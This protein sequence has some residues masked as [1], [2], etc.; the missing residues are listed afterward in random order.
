[1]VLELLLLGRKGRDSDCPSKGTART[2][3]LAFEN[4]RLLHTSS[5]LSSSSPAFPLPLPGGYITPPAPA[6]EEQPDLGHG[7]A[8]SCGTSLRQLR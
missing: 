4:R 3:V 6:R 5:P 7:G 2:Y 8:Q 1:M